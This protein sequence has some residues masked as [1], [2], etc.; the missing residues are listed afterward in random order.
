MSKEDARSVAEN[1]RGKYEPQSES[2][3]EK[4]RKTDAKVQRPARIFAYIFGIVG[5]LVLGIG[6]CLAMKI[7]GDLMPLGI[8]VGLLG[9]AMVAVDYPVYRAMLAARQK[10]YAAQILALTDELLGA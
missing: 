1:I 7:I 8:V 10:K 5:A 2:K 9:I 6:M 4:L 3:L